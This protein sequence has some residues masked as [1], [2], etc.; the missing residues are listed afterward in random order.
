MNIH[1]ILFVGL[2]GLMMSCDETRKVEAV[3]FSVTDIDPIPVDTTAFTD[4]TPSAEQALLASVPEIGT[5]TLSALRSDVQVIYTELGVPHLFGADK[6]DLA[7][8]LG[9]LMAKDR[10]WM[11]DLGRHLGA[12]RVSELLGDLA[13]ETDIKQRNLGIRAVGQRIYRFLSS[14]RRFIA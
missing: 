10:Y 9:Y 14:Q 1:P 6:R 2:V 8:V 5:M 4:P 11:M 3:P 12:G 13:L 7:I